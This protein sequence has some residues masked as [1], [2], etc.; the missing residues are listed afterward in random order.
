MT[1]LDADVWIA[2]LNTEDSQHA[3]AVKVFDE[4]E[5]REE[6]VAV[7]EYVVLEVVTVVRRVAGATIATAFMQVVAENTFVQILPSDSA[8]LRSVCFAV[9]H[10]QVPKLSFT[11]I[12]LLRLAEK[13][14]VI[15]FDR[16]L[17]RAI[18]HPVPEVFV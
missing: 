4:L 18:A 15:T 8:L 3:K 9:Y 2:Y 12:A 6:I 17:A 16:V 5:A 7:P 14:R 13:H 11:D 10:A 1:I